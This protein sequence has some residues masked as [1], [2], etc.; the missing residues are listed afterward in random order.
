MDAKFVAIRIL[1]NGNPAIGQFHRL[2]GERHPLR[3]QMRE[4]LVKVAYLQRNVW[5]IARWL[6]EGLLSNGQRMRANFILH[7]ESVGNIQGTGG[8]ESED[9]F[10]KSTG[11]C[12]I[13]RRIDDEGKFGNLNW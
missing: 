13:R 12:L 10:I 5:T 9:T 11:P 3:F 6:Q 7:P 1:N 8:L 4:S 2:K